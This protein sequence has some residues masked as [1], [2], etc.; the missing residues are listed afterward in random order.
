[1]AIPANLHH[2]VGHDLSLRNPPNS[3]QT[4]VAFVPRDE[5]RLWHRPSA[6]CVHRVRLGRA[7]SGFAASGASLPGVSCQPAS[8]R[9]YGFSPSGLREVDFRSARPTTH[10][11]PRSFQYR[12]ISRRCPDNQWSMCR[13]VVPGPA[14]QSFWPLSA[15]PKHSSRAAISVPWLLTSAVGSWPGLVI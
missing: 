11:R 4:G 6:P 8:V 15:T 7:S 10:Q 2:V 12:H 13:R 5:D 14:M 3:R 9:S 1:M